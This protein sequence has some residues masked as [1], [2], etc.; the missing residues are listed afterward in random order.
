MLNW[1]KDIIDF[2]RWGKLPREWFNRLELLTQVVPVWL[3]R[4]DTGSWGLEGSERQDRIFA[5]LW[6]GGWYFCLFIRG[7]EKWPEI[8]TEQCKWRHRMYLLGSWPQATLEHIWCSGIALQPSPLMISS[9][10]CKTLKWFKRF[11]VH[12]LWLLSLLSDR[13]FFVAECGCGDSYLTIGVVSNHLSWN[14]PSHC[15]FYETELRRDE[16][17]FTTSQITSRRAV[18]SLL[19]VV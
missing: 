13:K 1:K 18:G 11:S 4:R 6:F 7:M 3:Q 9:D 16:K 10:T 17:P 12:K 5:H 14:N 2:S 8:M 15:T 19:T